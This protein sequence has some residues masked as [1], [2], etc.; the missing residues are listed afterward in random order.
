MSKK[1]LSV[2]GATGLVGRTI[3]K[4]LEEREFPYGELTLFS[5]ARSAGEEV[6][7][8][9]SRLVMQELTEEAF[10]EHTDLALASAGRNVSYQLKEWVEGTDKVVVDNSSAFRMHPDVPLIVPEINPDAVA[11]HKG[12]IA[13]PNCSTIQLVMAMKPIAD[14]FGLGRVVVST[15]QSVSGAGQA[16]IE[17]L[18]KQTMDM[19]NGK[20]PAVAR[21]PRRIAFDL[22]PHIGAFDEEGYTEEEMKVTHETRKILGLPELGISC[23]AVRTP[24][25][26]CH[27]ESVMVET[28]K[29]AS[30]TGLKEVLAGFP[31]VKLVDDVKDHIYPVLADGVEIPDVLVGRVRRD[32]SAPNSYWLWIVADNVHKGAALNAVQIGELLT[33]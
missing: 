27:A 9:G 32:L 3:T 16:G 13:N 24:T 26:G 7:V 8:A 5:S 17:E 23:T 31:G 6:Y 33:C 11:G 14:R 10:L 18:S 15:Y 22:I 21:F 4:L 1:R 30:V 29:E 19:F 2:V 20:E 12:Y 25:F 28:Q